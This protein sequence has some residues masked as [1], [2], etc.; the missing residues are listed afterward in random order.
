MFTR[1]IFMFVIF[2][3]GSVAAFNLSYICYNIPIHYNGGW[4]KLCFACFLAI[5]L[6]T[7]VAT[8]RI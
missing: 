7:V 4:G 1:I 5:V 6:G 3:A 2:L 8:K